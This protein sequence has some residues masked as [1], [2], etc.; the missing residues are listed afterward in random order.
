MGVAPFGFTGRPHRV[1]DNL[2]DS[3]GGQVVFV[4]LLA[5][6]VP[7][8][9]VGTSVSVVLFVQRICGE[10]SESPTDEMASPVGLFAHG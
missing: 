7:S 8:L 4:Q 1:T 2:L 6:G 9:I 10:L 3:R 5:N